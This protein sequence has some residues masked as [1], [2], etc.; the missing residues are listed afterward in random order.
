L[1]RICACRLFSLDPLK[2]SLRQLESYPKLGAY[3][4]GCKSFFF[5]ILL[6][7]TKRQESAL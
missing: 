3:S 6:Q 2:R 4:S 1:T 7:V 5:L